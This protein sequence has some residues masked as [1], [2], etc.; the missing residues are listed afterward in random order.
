MC[1][2]V[3]AFL[4]VGSKQATAAV[5]AAAIYLGVVALSAAEPTRHW[6]IRNSEGTESDRSLAGIWVS[7]H[8]PK[9]F[10]VLT[11]WGNPAY[12][13]DRKVYDFSGLNTDFPSGSRD[14]VARYNPEILIFCPWRTGI[15]P[16]DYNSTPP[17]L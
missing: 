8:T 13:S 12:Y 14:F 11:G 4:T 10:T 1:H 17:H 7:Q 6:F 5:A 2:L 3:G 16:S 9:H 15:N